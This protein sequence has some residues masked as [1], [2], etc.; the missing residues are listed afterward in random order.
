VLGRIRVA[1]AEG[2]CEARQHESHDEGEI[3]DERKLRRKRL[4]GGSQEHVE[5]GRD[6]LQLQR[7]IGNGSDER[8]QADEG[9]DPLTLAV[10]SRDKVGDGGNVL[11]LRHPDDPGNEGIAQAD[12]EDR[13]DIDG[14]EVEAGMARKPH[15]SEEG[16]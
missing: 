10:A 1:G 3:A 4:V 11:R 15:R 2:D 7:D 14:E 16:P 12:D 8:D 9:G 6:R 13:A 5:R